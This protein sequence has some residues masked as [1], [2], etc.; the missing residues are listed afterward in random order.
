MTQTQLTRKWFCASLAVS[1]LV[2]MPAA[3]QV[4]AQDLKLIASDAAANDNFGAAIGVSGGILIIGAPGDDDAGNQ[5]GSAYV[6]DTTTGQELFK[7]TAS[8]AG[9]N[10]YFGNAVSISGSTAIVG[11]ASNESVYV[12]STKTGQELFKLTAS[13]G[14]SGDN[15]GNAVSVSGNTAVVAA[16]AD[17][18]QSGSVYV[19]D[20]TTGQQ[21]FKLMASDATAGVF[22]GSSVS[23]SGHTAVVGAPYDNSAGSAYVFDISTGQQLFKLIASDAGAGDQFGFAV[24]VSGNIA[25]I[26]APFDTVSGT[27]TG[28]VYVFDIT[29]GQQLFK[30]AG[31][32]AGTGDQFGDDV[33]ISD[34]IAIIGASTTNLFS[35]TAYLFDTNTG[36]QL[37]KLTASHLGT[38]DR[39]GSAVS[40]SGG[41]AVIGAYADDDSGTNAGAAYVFDGGPDIVQ[42]PLGRVVMPGQTA[43]LDVVVAVPGNTQFAWRRNGEI[44]VDGGNISGAGTP[45]LSIVAGEG[46]VAYYD[47][48]ITGGLWGSGSSI[49]T[50]VVLGLLADPNA[51][52]V[53]VNN[54]GLVNFFDISLFIN[55]FNAGCP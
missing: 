35:G 31:S 28:S 38:G 54:D 36:Q 20:T 44:L 24:S 55:A 42:Q 33:S 52:F 3:G 30:L 39:F 15:F 50:P 12:F 46:D 22:F 11:A 51:C 48:V 27:Q 4:I 25:V 18:S 1:L 2:A 41:T 14:V 7:L 45:T 10:D 34:D 23:I 17:D 16:F 32:D 49:S 40:I 9:A 26:G 13:D 5:S 21:Q 43:M 53:D 37:F 29:T 19:F 8:D 6:V 47:C